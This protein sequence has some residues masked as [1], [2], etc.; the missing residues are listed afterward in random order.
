[1][2]DEK[3][4][5]FG[6]LHNRVHVEGVPRKMRVV[7]AKEYEDLKNS[8]DALQIEI[9]ELKKANEYYSSEIDR[10]VSVS[11]DALTE[12]ENLKEEIKELECKFNEWE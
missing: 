11:Y 12:N 10:L 4:D 1:M 7:D 3:E 6:L 8:R 5:E 9:D 2:S